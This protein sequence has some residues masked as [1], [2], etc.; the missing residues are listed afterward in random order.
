[1]CKYIFLL[2]TLNTGCSVISL[3]QKILIG[4]DKVKSRSFCYLMD[5]DFLTERYSS[6]YT[7]GSEEQYT[8]QI[9]IS[10]ASYRLLAD[11]SS[12]TGL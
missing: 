6:T 12:Q 11:Y 8:G 10:P 2:S 5:R 3:V 4:L 7:V 9:R 1:M